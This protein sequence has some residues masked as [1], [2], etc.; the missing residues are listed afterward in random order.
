M[1]RMNRTTRN[2]QAKEVNTMLNKGR[3]FTLIELLVVIA[4]IAILA[5]ILFPVFAKAREKARQTSCLSNVK[6]L[7]LACKMYASDW[8]DGNP[9]ACGGRHVPDRGFGL[10]WDLAVLPYVANEQIFICPTMAKVMTGHFWEPTYTP[11]W[12]IWTL[13]AESPDEVYGDLN[14]RIR[15]GKYSECNFP[16][17]VIFLTEFNSSHL[18]TW[19]GPSIWAPFCDPILYPELGSSNPMPGIG[20][21]AVRHNEGCN[22]GFADGHAK[23]MSRA[24]AVDG[25]VDFFAA[26]GLSMT[27]YYESASYDSDWWLAQFDKNAY[28]DIYQDLIM[29]GLVNE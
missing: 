14:S 3:G 4:I 17:E 20:T 12:P 13:Y 9:P 21:P 6:Q 25:A 1:A 23:W 10:Y 22:Y 24:S 27:A 16:A 26:S 19:E 8:D 2:P 29:W 11:I 28:P 5:A 15:Y 7:T 18:Q